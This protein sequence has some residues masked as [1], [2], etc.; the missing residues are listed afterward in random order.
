MGT[1][2]SPGRSTK[3]RSTTYG[4]YIVKLIGS[5]EIFLSIPANLFVCSSIS[6]LIFSKSK[7][8]SPFLC[9]N[10]P[11]SSLSYLSKPP[12][13]LKLLCFFIISDACVLLSCSTSGHLVTMP[14]PLGR[15]SRPTICSSTDDFPV[16]WEPITTI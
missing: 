14:W 9:K 1:F 8:F 5:S 7:N 12:L 2:A 15:K 11:Y 6:Y 3:V 13:P 10:S 16:D 4:E